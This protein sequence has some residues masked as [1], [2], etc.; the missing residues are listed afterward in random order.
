MPGE[1]PAEGQQRQ[2]F[3]IQLVVFAIFSFCCHLLTQIL[4][5]SH[6]DFISERSQPHSETQCCGWDQ[7]AL[8]LRFLLSVLSGRLVHKP[9]HSPQ[10]RENWVTQVRHPQCRD[11]GWSVSL[12]NQDLFSPVD[13]LGTLQKFADC[14][15]KFLAL[16]SSVELRG[17]Y[18]SSLA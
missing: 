11:F 13:M 3:L 14:Q 1:V 2:C 16:A 8:V 17:D 5:V 6:P 9:H 4:A 12:S 15:D 7:L 18:H 10:S